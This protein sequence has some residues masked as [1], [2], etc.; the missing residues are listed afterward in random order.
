VDIARNF[1]RVNAV[2]CCWVVWLLNNDTFF[3]KKDLFIII[4][5]YTVADFRHTRRG[6]QVSLWVVA[7]I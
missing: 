3:L 1:S 5:K 7:E 6:C 4:N 2:E